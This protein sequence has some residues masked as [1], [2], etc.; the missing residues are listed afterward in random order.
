MKSHYKWSYWA[1]VAVA[2]LTLLAWLLPKVGLNDTH[3]IWWLQGIAFAII[4]ILVGISGWQD[5]KNKQ[6]FGPKLLFILALV[7]I[8]IFYVLPQ[9][10]F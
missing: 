9:F 5:C 1:I 7:V 4:A 2:V 3:L 8:V 6:D 10:K